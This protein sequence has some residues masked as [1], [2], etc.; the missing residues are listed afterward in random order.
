MNVLIRPLLADD[1]DV[2]DRVMRTAFGTFLG[3]PDPIR[4]FG[5]VEYIRPR[6]AAEPAWA[7]AAEVDGEVIGSNVATRWGSFGF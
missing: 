4:V 7:Y 2:A 3:A 1:L 5:D 6:F